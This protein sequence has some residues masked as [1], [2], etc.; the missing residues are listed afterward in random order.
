MQKFSNNALTSL[1]IGVDAIATTI[2]VASGVLFPATAGGDHFLITLIGLDGNG[3]ESTWEICKVTFRDGNEFTVERGQEGTAAQS[4]PAGT[5]VELRLTAGSMVAPDDPRLSDAR[6]WT[7]ATVTQAEAEAGTST[8]A[9]KWTAQRVF[10]GVAAWWNASAHKTKLDGIEAGAQVNDVTSVA[11]RTGTV[12]LGISDIASLQTTLDGKAASSHAHAD[13]TT[14]AAGFMSA[15]DKTKLNGVATGANNYSHPTGDGNLHVPETGT[16]NNGKVLK[17]GSTAGSLS[18]GT[19]SYTDV[20]AAAE[21]HTHNY[22]GSAT[23][24][25]AAASVAQTLTRGTYLTGSNFNGS[26]ATTWA[27]DATSANTASK[28]VARDASGNFAAGTITAALNGNAATATKL[29]TARTINGVSF[30]GTANI[31]ISTAQPV[32]G[33]LSGTAIAWGTNAK[34]HATVSANTTFSFSSNPAVGTTCLLHVTHTSGTI[35]WPASVRWPS[36]VAPTLT[37]NRTHIFMFYWD[38]ACYRGSFLRNYVTT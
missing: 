33:T 25:G 14:S 18:W 5:R 20:G 34:W 11:G 24:G 1:A 8:T 6:E 22:A 38:G 10:Q 32:P 36:G 28:V 35:T 30:D 9:R 29:A 16:T 17:A 21:S 4:W 13:A 3:N 23:A 27:V 15:A 37:T 7:G 26:A 2:H 12:T 19:L 31:T